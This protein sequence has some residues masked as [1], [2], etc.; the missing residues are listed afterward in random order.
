MRIIGGDLKGKKLATPKGTDIRPSADRLREA[1]FNILAN[2]LQ[3]ATVLDL[4]AG[5]GAF[6]IEAL[7]RGA[8]YSVFIDNKKKALAL[9]N[10]NIFACKLNGQSRIIQWDITKNI[11]CIQDHQP[12]FDVVFMDPPYERG[13][14]AKA[15]LQLHLSRSLNQGARV[16]VEHSINEALPKDLR[17]FVFDDRRRYGKTLV[18]FLTNVI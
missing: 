6:G 18:T 14:L 11:N 4:F 13:N 9:L 10:R 17:C 8:I 1:V 16:I 3:G 7:S 15:L 2:S 5:T 12:P